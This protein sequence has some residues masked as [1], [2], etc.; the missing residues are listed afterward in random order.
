MKYV[1]GNLAKKTPHGS[2][3]GGGGGEH[4]YIYC[5]TGNEKCHL[6]PTKQLRT[7]PL[8]RVDLQLS[9]LPRPRS[10]ARAAYWA[11][12]SARLTSL[13]EG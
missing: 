7:A 6:G 9:N 8:Q 12:Q 4:I 1:A 3:L 2:A 10:S 11:V 5:L 13:Y